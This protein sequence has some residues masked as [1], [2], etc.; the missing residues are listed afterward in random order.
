MLKTGVQ[1]TDHSGT[2][3]LE[4]EREKQKKEREKKKNERVLAGD[5]ESGL[6]R[7]TQRGL[8][9]PESRLKRAF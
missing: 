2:Q 9:T 7:D 5:H 6:S 1:I 3:T 8:D 4:R